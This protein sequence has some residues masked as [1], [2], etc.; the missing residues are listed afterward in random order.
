MSVTLFTSENNIADIH[1]EMNTL[2]YSACVAPVQLEASS[3]HTKIRLTECAVQGWVATF[4]SFPL[5]LSPQNSSTHLTLPFIFQNPFPSLARNTAGLPNTRSTESQEFAA[6]RASSRPPPPGPV[7][8]GR[9]TRGP[10]ALGRGWKRGSPQARNSPGAADPQA[11]QSI[12]GARESARIDNRQLGGYFLRGLT[13]YGQG[14][15]RRGGAGRPGCACFKCLAAYKARRRG[16]GPR[17]AVR[18]AGC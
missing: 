16:C 10:A 13:K 6:L 9:R 7:P 18:A 3:V 14:R 11:A 1:T 2:F 15:A 12:G 4:S 17:A 5:D 8:S